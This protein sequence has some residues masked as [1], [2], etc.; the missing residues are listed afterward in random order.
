MNRNL[1]VLPILAFLALAGLF[2]YRLIL[3]EQGNT[4]NKIPSVMIDHPAPAFTLAPLLEGKPGLAANDLLGHVTYVN[5]FASWCIPCRQEHPILSRL[6]G[7]GLILVGIDYKDKLEEAQNWLARLGDPYS[8]IGADKD[9]RVAI[10]F[11][12]YGVPESYLIDK[13]GRIRFKQT[14]PLTEES[15]QRD[16]LP[17]VAELNK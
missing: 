12:N 8:A 17:L 15:L 5:F 6:Q 9:G 16:I 7:K 13:Q 2:S 10:D 11:G 4:P 3:I 1:Y 14:G